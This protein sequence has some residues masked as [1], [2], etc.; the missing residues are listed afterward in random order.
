MTDVL[1]ACQARGARGMLDWSVR[2]LAKRSKV[3]HSSIRRI[4]DD[5]GKPQSVTM[6]LRFKL[7]AYFESRGFT[8]RSDPELGPGV[9]WNRSPKR[10]R[11]NG[12]AERRAQ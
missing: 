5:C 11:R 9:F 2:E 7:Q 1:L 3:S 8:F 4:E 10:E 12:P 6:D